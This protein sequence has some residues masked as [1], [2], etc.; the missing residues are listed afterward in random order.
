MEFTEEDLTT[1]VH[2]LAAYLVT[3]MGSK[4]LARELSQ[5]AAVRLLKVVEEGQAIRSPRGWL[6]Q[7][8]RNLAVD[9][10]RRNLPH[11][12]GLEWRSREI[13]PHS[14]DEEDVLFALEGM[15]VPRTELLRMMPQAM[16]SLPQ[17]DREDLMAYYHRGMDFQ[18]L[19]EDRELSVTTVKGRLYRAR[20]RLRE[21]LVHQARQEKNRW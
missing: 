14:M 7:V 3:R 19:A 5:E 16:K 17:G 15:E 13:D 1:W 4:E 10:I 8:G 21:Q 12:V 2:Q 6:F 20:H 11:P 9:E 18:A